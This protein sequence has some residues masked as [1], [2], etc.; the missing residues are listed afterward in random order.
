MHDKDI[1]LL[2]NIDVDCWS[3]SEMW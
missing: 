2:I 1:I 3:T